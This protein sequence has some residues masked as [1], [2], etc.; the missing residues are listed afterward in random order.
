MRKYPPQQT[1]FDPPPSTEIEE[2]WLIY[3]YDV[4]GNRRDGF[5][6]NNEFRTGKSIR[7]PAGGTNQA[8]IRVL[9][10]GGYIARWTG[11]EAPDEDENDIWLENAKTGEPLLHLQRHTDE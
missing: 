2:R 4:W 8:I 9:K 3:V 11:V 1:L 5:E 10:R 6:V 7:V